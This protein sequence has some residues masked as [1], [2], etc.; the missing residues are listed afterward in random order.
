MYSDPKPSFSFLILLFL[1]LQPLIFSLSTDA[2]PPPTVCIVGSG[3]GG[4]S[5]AHFLRHYFH[6]SPSQPRPPNI[7]I[8][9]RSYVV[10]GRMATVSIGGETFEAGASI[11]HPKN[12]HALN[13]SNLLGLKVK[14]PPASEDDDSMSLGIWDGKKFVFKTLQVDSKFPLVQKI[15]FYVNSFRIFFRYGFSLLK[16]GSFVESTVD[17]FLK[18]YESPERRPIFETVDEMLKWAGLYNLTTQTLQDELIGIKLSPLLIEELVTVITRI[19][20][21]QSVYISGLAGAVSLAGSG[22]GLWA[23]DGG[24]WQMASGLINSSDVSLHLNEEIESISYLGE[25]Y[26]LNSTKGNSYSCEVAVVATPLDE[27]NIR[28]SPAVSIPERKLQHTHATFVRGLLNPAYFG[29]RTVAEIPELVGTLEDSDLPFTCISV[30]K[31]L[32]ENDITYKI[33]SR[34]PLSDALLDSIFSARLQTNRINW[35]AYPHYK[36]PELFAPFI[37]DGQH[38]YYVNAFENAASTMETS[39][40]AAENVARLILSRYFSE[41]SLQSSN[42][43]SFSPDADVSHF[44][45]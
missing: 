40:V 3:I 1:C 41:A 44:D 7:K 29:L 22:G 23:V 25:Y 31:Q 12:Y 32:D 10:G 35:G 24:N 30:L 42:L 27:V 34:E 5:V 16:M 13:Y 43:Q 8:F 26:E 17:S 14:P 33:F 36:A 15:V 2:S 20:Y 9:E 4:S 45:L 18:Y 39:A 21:G 19:N 11:L 38:L 6:P 28:F 37:L